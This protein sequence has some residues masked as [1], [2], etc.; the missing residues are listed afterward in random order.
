[1]LQTDWI[2]FRLLNQI[3]CHIGSAFHMTEMGIADYSYQRWHWVLLAVLFLL[4][5][6]NTTEGGQQESTSEF[7]YP[8]KLV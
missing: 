8:M 3:F 1:M 6:T 5:P 2:H 7:Y 4:K